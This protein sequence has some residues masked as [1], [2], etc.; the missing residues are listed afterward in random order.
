MVQKF[1]KQIIEKISFVL[2]FE[3]YKTN[4]SNKQP[5][6]FTFDRREEEKILLIPLPNDF[7]D[8]FER[9]KPFLVQITHELKT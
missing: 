7:E 4:L 3:K 5:A 1:K 8:F 2:K 9:L 6:N